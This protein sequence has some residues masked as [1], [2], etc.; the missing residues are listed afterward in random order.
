[1]RV[2]QDR[3]M[4]SSASSKRALGLLRRNAEALELGVPVALADAE[5]EPAA[6]DQIERRGLLGEQ[7][8]VVPGQRHD[9][10]PEPQPGRAHRQAGQQ[11]QRGRDLVPAGEMMLDQEAR[12]QAQRLRLDVEVE[13]IAESLAGPLV[14]LR[15]RLARV[16]LRR[17]EQ[18]KTHRHSAACASSASMKPPDWRRHSAA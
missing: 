9:R 3:R 8:R 18:T 4:T 11:H 2:V 1:M 12:M 5:V 13:I 16:G 7:D 10:G 6:G 17:T 14:V 15:A